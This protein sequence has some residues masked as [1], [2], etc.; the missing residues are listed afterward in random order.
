MHSRT[1]NP[2]VVLVWRWLYFWVHR[3]ALIAERPGKEEYKE[4]QMSEKLC[5]K[6][7]S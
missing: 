2:F 4:T 5:K 1:R 7:E 3:L 6:K